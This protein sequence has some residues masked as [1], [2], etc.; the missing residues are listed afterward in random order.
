MGNE[1]ENDFATLSGMSGLSGAYSKIEEEDRIIRSIGRPFSPEE[2]SVFVSQ[3]DKIEEN[4]RDY[5]EAH[6]WLPITMVDLNVRLVLG[7]EVMHWALGQDDLGNEVWFHGENETM[8]F[9]RG[10]IIKVFQ[11][12]N[13]LNHGILCLERS[14]HDYCIRKEDKKYSVLIANR[15]HG[16]YPTSREKAIVNALLAMVGKED[17][18]YFVEEE[19]AAAKADDERA[20]KEPCEESPPVLKG[21]STPFLRR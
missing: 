8:P 7:Q 9:L 3:F 2:Y 16:E 15:W 12:E 18:G 5:D 4:S 17:Q 1:N 14:G 11:P 19:K 20:K 10:S 6:P 21:I 13:N